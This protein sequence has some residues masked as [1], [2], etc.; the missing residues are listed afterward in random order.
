MIDTAWLYIWLWAECA[1]VAWQPARRP[2]PDFLTPEWIAV[3]QWKELASG[4]VHIW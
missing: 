4:R 1:T 3:P 2:Y